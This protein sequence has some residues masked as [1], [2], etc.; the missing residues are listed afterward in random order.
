MFEILLEPHER[1]GRGWAG[2]ERA[3]VSAV[4]PFEQMMITIQFASLLCTALRC[5]KEINDDAVAA[6]G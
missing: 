2:G 4:F 5:L 3:P 1:E 6:F